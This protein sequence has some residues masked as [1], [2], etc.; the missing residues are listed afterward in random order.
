MDDNYIKQFEPIDGKWY[1]KD[2][3]GKGAFGT[4]YEIER[5]DFS[6][7]KAALKVISIP[8]DRSEVDSYRQE[9]YDLD[10]ESITSYFYG[11]VKGFVEEFKLMSKLKGNSN[12]V[13]YEDHDVKER[14]D[15]IGWDIFIRMELLTPMNVYFSTYSPTTQDV[16]KIG[17][18]ICKALEV[19]QKY[20]IIHRDIKPSNI[21]ISDN[22]DYKLGDFGVARTLEKTSSGLSKKGT[23]TY[24]APEIYKG[25]KYNSNVDIYSLGI[26]MYKLLNN[27][28][29]PFRVTRTYED[30]ERSIQRRMSGE[31]IPEPANAGK[32]L[33]EIII[34]ACAYSPK[35]RYSSAK[36]MRFDLEKLLDSSVTSDS[37]SETDNSKT[38]DIIDPSD[39]QQETVIISEKD[40]D[41]TFGL[42]PWKRS[43]KIDNNKKKKTR[44]KKNNIKPLILEC[45][46]AATFII[47]AVGLLTHISNNKHLDIEVTNEDIKLSV[48]DGTKTDIADVIPDVDKD[49]QITAKSDN[50]GIV[51]ITQD[52]EDT[53]IVCNDIGSANVTYEYQVD[54][55]KKETDI[56][57]GIIEIDVSM[58]KAEEKAIAA[59]KKELN[60]KLSEAKDLLEK[61]KKDDMVDPMNFV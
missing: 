54:V 36:K 25:Q 34:K 31:T 57:S 26:V 60:K 28:M 12:I 45:T 13:S 29:E 59:G 11:F 2:I 61:V 53:Y 33:S 38:I 15:G 18:D 10:D 37:D 51:T 39:D 44:K 14:K 48:E 23:Y 58:S 55:T 24:M 43:K 1:I 19:C 50:Q 8:S 21:F 3:I 16:I 40:H 22:G 35:E 56:V 49:M 42:F 5:K 32:E 52:G 30:S 46:V 20:K 4:V 6:D 27:N 7:M 41:K 47:G 17:I 9:N